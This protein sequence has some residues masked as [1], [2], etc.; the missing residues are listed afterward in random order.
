M[1]DYICDCF[2][3]PENKDKENEWHVISVRILK[4]C[5]YCGSEFRRKV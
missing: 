1:K 5:P 3:K 2:C 4:I